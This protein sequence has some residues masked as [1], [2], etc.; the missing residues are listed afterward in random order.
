MAKMKLSLLDEFKFSDAAGIDFFESI[1][2]SI[3]S[4]SCWYRQT[5]RKI[6]SLNIEDEFDKAIINRMFVR[7]V[8]TLNINGDSE[9]DLA[10]LFSLGW[11]V[12]QNFTKAGEHFKR[13][14]ELG[15]HSAYYNLGLLISAGHVKD[16]ISADFFFAKAVSFAI[17]EGNYF[18]GLKKEG[19]F[20]VS[21]TD[22]RSDYADKKE[23]AIVNAIPYYKKSA[24][25]DHLPSIIRLSEIYKNT[26]DVKDEQ[27]SLYYALKAATL[28]HSAS[29]LLAADYLTH[30]YSPRIVDPLRQ[31]KNGSLMSATTADD[32]GQWLVENSFDKVKS[33]REILKSHS[34]DLNAALKLLEQ[35]VKK[36]NKYAYQ[37]IAD[38]YLHQKN[39]PLRAIIYYEF[40]IKEDDVY[41]YVKLG[42]LY[43]STE[44]FRNKALAIENYKQF[45]DKATV[46]NMKRVVGGLHVT[47]SEV[48]MAI[49][50]LS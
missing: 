12:E 2:P 34:V 31:L 13:A 47:R 24:E 20:R 15:S 1:R 6:N 49:E 50:R 21:Q 42:H 44:G 16:N 11:C 48:K 39:D 32:V 18:L 14:I 22:N 33:L 29:M 28:G 43:E 7:S 45:L 10:I 3:R 5:V 30:G 27:A 9:N 8:N 4:E 37:K 40:A 26:F 36:G 38:L 46:D 41:C 19:D 23:S 35:A 17:V 25:A